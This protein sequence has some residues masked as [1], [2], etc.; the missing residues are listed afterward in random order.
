MVGWILILKENARIKDKYDFLP[1]QQKNFPMLKKPAAL[2]SSK[3][4]THLGHLNSPVSI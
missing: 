4:A 1:T 3:T 2:L